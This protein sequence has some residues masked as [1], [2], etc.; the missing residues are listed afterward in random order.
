M[1]EKFE[2]I[3]KSLIVLQNKFICAKNQNCGF[4]GSYGGQVCDLV[5]HLSSIALVLLMPGPY[6]RNLV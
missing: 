4:I 2:P 5:I 3:M 1:R 6:K